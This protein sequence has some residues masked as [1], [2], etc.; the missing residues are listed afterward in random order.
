MELKDAVGITAASLAENLGIR[1]M[2]LK[3]FSNP[4]FNTLF[5][6]LESVQWN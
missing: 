4:A 3:G 6:L 1:S 2:E 5:S